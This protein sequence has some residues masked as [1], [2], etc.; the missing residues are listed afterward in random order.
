[1]A[2]NRKT[3]PDS[4]LDKL[5]LEQQDAVFTRCETISLEDGVCWIKT[6]FKISISEMCLSRWLRKHRASRSVAARLDQIQQ[7]RDQATLIGNVVGTAT[8]ITAANIVL[9]AQAVFDE[10]LKPAEER[11]EE[12][13]AQYMSLAIKVDSQHYK[14]RAGDLAFERF[15]FDAARKALAFTSKLQRINESGVDD[16]AKIEEAMALLFGKPVA[17]EI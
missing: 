9:I 4:R 1:M 7:A 3:R 15:H 13:L 6:E 8:E 11:D 2:T 17:V 10:L 14:A 12:K 16:R 5:T